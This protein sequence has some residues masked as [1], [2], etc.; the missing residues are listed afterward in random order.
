[1]RVTVLYFDGCP[2]WRAA[3]AR[4]REAIGQVGRSDIAVTHRQVLS[5]ED[6]ETLPFRGSPTILVDGRDP[7]ADPQAPVGL[8]CRV[9]TTDAGL[10]G[11]PTVEQLVEALDG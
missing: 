7:F 10:A 3:D 5:P 6:A 8:S 9:Y 2:N 11:A 4:L 1:M